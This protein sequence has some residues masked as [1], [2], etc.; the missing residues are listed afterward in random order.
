M[1]MNRNQFFMAGLV[2]LFLGLQFRAIESV[3]LT[4]QVTRLLAETS[5]TPV[6]ATSDTMSSLWG[7]EPKAVAAP[8][9]PPDWLGWFLVSLGAIFVLHSMAM[10]RPSA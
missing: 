1:D 6:V 4:P 10:P 5:G 9:R 7:T 3:V 2:L 8:M